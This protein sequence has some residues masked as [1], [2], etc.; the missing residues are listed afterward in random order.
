M[1][2]V[3]INGVVAGIIGLR[4]KVKENAKTVVEKL[5]KSNID[6]VMI[7]G[8][9][10]KTASIIANEIGIK[11]VVSNVTPKQKAESVKNFKKSG[12][13]MMCGDGIN[14]SVSLVTADI[15]VSVSNGTDIAINRCKRCTYK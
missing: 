4:D 10:E 12:Y 7:T 3:S 15:G 13:V 6:V 1:L 8:D 5:E 2:I 14:D 9:N 11:N